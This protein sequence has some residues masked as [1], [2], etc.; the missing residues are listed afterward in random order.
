MKK[1]RSL[2]CMSTTNHNI[3]YLVDIPCTSSLNSGNRLWKAQ[4]RLAL[5]GFPAQ[6]CP[7]T[8]AERASAALHPCF[9]PI[10]G[11]TPLQGAALVQNPA[12]PVRVVDNWTTLGGQRNSQADTLVQ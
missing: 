4:K 5:C 8:S 9:K 11:A 10:P 12:Q 1:Y 6:I 3:L 7:K 2:W